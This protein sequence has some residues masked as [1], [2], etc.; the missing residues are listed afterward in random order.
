VCVCVC[1]CVCVG[2]QKPFI[3]ENEDHGSTRMMAFGLVK[4]PRMPSGPSPLPKLTQYRSW[5]GGGVQ[6]SNLRSGACA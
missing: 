3:T 2:K 4:R 1:V 6:R 5:G